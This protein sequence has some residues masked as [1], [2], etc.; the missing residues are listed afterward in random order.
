MEEKKI[1]DQEIDNKSPTTESSR[2]NAQPNRQEVDLIGIESE[3]FDRFNTQQ[4]REPTEEQRESAEPG[5]E[6][7][8]TKKSKNN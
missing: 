5:T 4:N 8:R 6:S 2:V 1:V 3:P 7:T